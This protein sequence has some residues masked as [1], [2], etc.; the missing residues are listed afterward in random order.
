MVAVLS[1][2]S[3]GCGGHIVSVSHCAWPLR[4]ALQ[5]PHCA[6]VPPLVT[7]HITLIHGAEMLRRPTVSTSATIIYFVPIAQLLP[8]RIEEKLIYSKS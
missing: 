8:V 3:C 7:T 6:V 5:R 2:Q 1:E 4:S